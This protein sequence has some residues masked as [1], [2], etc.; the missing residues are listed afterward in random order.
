M[1]NLIIDKTDEIQSYE[2]F[3]EDFKVDPSV[4]IL[5]KNC[6][7][8][9]NEYAQLNGHV[10]LFQVISQ[11][12]QSHQPI[13]AI[14][15]L[16][17]DR[18][19][20]AASASTKREASIQAG[21]KVLYQLCLDARQ[22][23]RFITDTNCTLFDRIASKILST[24]RDLCL[25]V[26]L[27][28]IGCKVLAGFVLEEI[29][30]QTLT[31]IC[32]ATG[33]K[34][35]GGSVLSS[36]G[37]VVHDSH[38]EQLARR[39]FI[40]YL[41]QQID[42]FQKN[43]E[44]IFEKTTDDKLILKSTIRIHFYTSFAPCGDSALFTPRDKIVEAT[45]KDEH[46]L[47]RTARVQGQLRSK[48]ENG[49]GTIP[50]EIKSS[51]LSLDA[52]TNGK[53]IRHMSCSDKIFRWNVLGIQGA[54]L[55]HIIQPIYLNSITIG[56][57]FHYGHLC[58]ALCCRLQDYFHS[59]PLPEP[60]R[61]NHPLIGHTKFKW[62]EEINRNT[63]SDDSLNWNIADNN[64]ELIEPSTGKRKP[65]NEI[66]RLCK[67][68]IFQ[69][70]KNINTTDRKSYYQMKQTSSIYQQCKYQMFRGFELYYSTGWISKDP[71]LSMFL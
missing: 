28:L 24:Y 37:L 21:Y 30:K 1:S 49:E 71:S 34:S 15:V 29:D 2:D 44:S 22:T 70:Y 39:G 35:V 65:N 12:G 19:F 68:E 32:L 40:R 26:Q 42:Y 23:Q 41:Y 3:L 55:S 67:S 27:E 62:K 56:F 69:L 11:S 20:P 14:A 6:L 4:T 9:L 53:H 58:R 13:F 25:S 52:I 59:N 16:L 31:V 45:V 5:S 10:L 64:I 48:I 43:Q 50:T 7:T 18:Q 38:A 57:P 63:N 51:I 60:Y 33:N 17:D 8:L 54:L 36:Q 66:S 61:L 46:D 47:Y